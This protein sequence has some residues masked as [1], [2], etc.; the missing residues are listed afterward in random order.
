M[1]RG[2]VKLW[3]KTLDSGLLQHST[4]WQLFGYLLL[5][6]SHRPHKKIVNGKVFELEAGQLVFSRSDAAAKLELG[7]RQVRTA[8]SI[9]EKLE[10]VTSRPTNKGSIISF[11]NWDRYNGGRPADDQQ[12]DPQGDQHP[13]STRPA[14]AFAS[15]NINKNGKNKEIKNTLCGEPE[16]LPPYESKDPLPQAILLPSVQPKPDPDFIILPAK[17]EKK[18][19]PRNYAVTESQVGELSALYPA[20]DVRQELRNMLGWLKSH[21]ANVKVN[22]PRFIHS[23][24]RNSQDGSPARAS[25]MRKP[26]TPTEFQKQL[27]DRR[28]MASALLEIRNREENHEKENTS[29]AGSFSPGLSDGTNPGGACPA[30]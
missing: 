21:P 22:V 28:M 14:E 6:A 27:Q 23:W 26:S 18:G 5:N 9:L 19:V 2:Y 16:V 3:R 13:T 30:G 25:P 7:E 11:V 4:A 29:T 8:L 15:S 24:L 12:D 1:D 17:P 20:V 10:I